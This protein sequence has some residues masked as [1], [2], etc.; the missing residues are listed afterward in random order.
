MMVRVPLQVAQEL[1]QLAD[2]QGVS[3]SDVAGRL[4][5]VGLAAEQPTSRGQG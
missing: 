1:E 5:T 3:L 4:I 2:Q